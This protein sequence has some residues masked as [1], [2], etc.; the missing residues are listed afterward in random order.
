MEKV[1][2]KIGEYLNTLRNNVVVR[3]DVDRHHKGRAS[4]S[5]QDNQSAATAKLSS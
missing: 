3:K 5:R 1:T 4:L 2:G